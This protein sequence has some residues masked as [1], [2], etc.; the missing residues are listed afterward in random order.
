[1]KLVDPSGEMLD[2]TWEQHAT[3]LANCPTTASLL[4]TFATLVSHLRIDLSAPASIVYARDT[5]PSGQELVEALETGLEAFGNVKLN[6]VGITTT[7]VLHYVVKATN[8]K[9][10][11]YGAPTIE[12]YME[13]MAKAFKT[14]IVSLALSKAEF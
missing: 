6:D 11:S 4:S 8:D 14:L 7:P 3:A 12:G 13:K 10:G 1:V 2:Q 9:T 5:R